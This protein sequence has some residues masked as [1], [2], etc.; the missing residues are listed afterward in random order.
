MI[1][2]FDMNINDKNNT[3]NPHNNPHYTSGKLTRTRDYFLVYLSDMSYYPKFSYFTK[4]SVTLDMLPD[5]KL[6]KLAHIR[7]NFP[8]ALREGLCLVS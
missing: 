2:W 4:I 8:R 3:V 1:Y 6:L 5:I 7:P